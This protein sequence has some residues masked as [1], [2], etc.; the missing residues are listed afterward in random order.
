VTPCPDRRTI[1]YA[2]VGP[3]PDAGPG[4]SPDAVASECFPAAP[5]SAFRDAGRE[6]ERETDGMSTQQVVPLPVGAQLWQR[7]LTV[8]PLVLVG[9]LDPDGSPDLAPKHMAMPLGWDDRFCFACT[10]R[11]STYANALAR[12]V[13][14]V[15]FPTPAQ[16]VSAG[17]A[18]T[19]READASKPALAALA[20]V[21]ARV[22][23]GVLVEGA[24]LFLE[25]E[26]DRTVDLEGASLVIGRIVA[27]A[28][29]ELALRTEGDDADLAHELPLLAYLAPGRFAEIHESRSFP[30]PADFRL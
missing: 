24:Y 23:D 7:V 13:F 27:A 11:H 25:C 22:V 21:P 3:S 5:I 15:S 19:A 29:D 6:G 12:G 26:L 17:L 4:H 16:V 2:G 10:P 1:A 28:A 9:T 30:F 18:A 14:T 20:T 8:A